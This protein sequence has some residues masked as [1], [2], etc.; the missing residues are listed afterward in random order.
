MEND[1]LVDKWSLMIVRRITLKDTNDDQARC[2]QSMSDN[3]S[4]SDYINSPA[5][6]ARYFVR[7]MCKIPD[8]SRTNCYLWGVI[9][10]VELI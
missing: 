4:N 7:S 2:H 5:E 1:Q 10:T 9:R 6:R 3:K 8:I